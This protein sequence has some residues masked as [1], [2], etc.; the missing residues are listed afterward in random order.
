MFIGRK[1]ELAALED[2]YQRTDDIDVKGRIRKYDKRLVR[3]FIERVEVK[4]ESLVI[5]F[6]AGVSVE[7]AG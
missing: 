5:C 3:R 2:F 7:V 4:S 6:K 1:R